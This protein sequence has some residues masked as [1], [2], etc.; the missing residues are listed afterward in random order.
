MGLHVFMW[1]IG[2]QTTDRAIIRQGKPS[3]DTIDPIKW[4]VH[5]VAERALDAYHA[6]RG[7]GCSI[8]EV[9]LSLESGEIYDPRTGRMINFVDARD[10]AFRD[11]CHAMLDA[12]STLRDQQVFYNLVVIGG[13]G[14]QMLLDAVKADDALHS[15]TE[16]WQLVSNPRR[17]VVEGMLK[18][19][20]KALRAIEGKEN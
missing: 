10:K 2:S 11:I 7:N 17:G 9:D 5:L 1:D 4:G 19:T 13:G 16:H 15:A 8:E 18:S 12:M 14:A 3:V 20:L 6:A